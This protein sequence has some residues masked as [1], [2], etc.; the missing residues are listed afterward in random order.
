MTAYKQKELIVTVLIKAQAW[1]A[2]AFVPESRPSINTV[3]K[4]FKNGEI[5]GCML[6]GTLYIE[7]Q[8]GKACTGNLPTQQTWR[9]K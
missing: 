3:K 7:L 6:G 2:T 4:W 9:V 8:D 1:I 5:D